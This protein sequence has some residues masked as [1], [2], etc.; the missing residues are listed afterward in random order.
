MG[1]II[2][3][4]QNRKPASRRVWFFIPECLIRSQAFARGNI[5]ALVDRFPVHYVPPRGQVIRTLVLV[6]QVVGVLPNIVAEDGKIAFAIHQRIVLIGGRADLEFA[7]G[8]ADEPN[9]S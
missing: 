5:E 7:G 3:V 6:A 9:P 1:A 2:A 8:G 4:A